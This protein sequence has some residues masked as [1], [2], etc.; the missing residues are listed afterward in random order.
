MFRLLFL[1]SP[2]LAPVREIGSGEKCGLRVSSFRHAVLRGEDGRSR[3]PFS[4]GLD[5]GGLLPGELLE[6]RVHWCLGNVVGVV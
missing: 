1:V 5:H 3:S 4:G 6:H 2:H